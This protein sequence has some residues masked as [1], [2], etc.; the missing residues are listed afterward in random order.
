MSLTPE[1]NKAIA[2]AEDTNNMLISLLKSSISKEENDKKVHQQMSSK[3]VQ[4][5]ATIKKLIDS[6]RVWLDEFEAR[7]DND[8]CPSPEI[9]KQYIDDATYMREAF[10]RNDA[11]FINRVQDWYDNQPL[12]FRA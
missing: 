6:Q 3:L 1:I 8:E 2:T 5:E 4:Y 9:A 10:K 11:G 12:P 7:F